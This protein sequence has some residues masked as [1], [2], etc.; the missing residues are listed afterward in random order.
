MFFPVV[1]SVETTFDLDV[2]NKNLTEGSDD[3]LDVKQD[4]E[5]ALFVEMRKRIPGLTGLIVTNIR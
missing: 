3:Y 5:M 1:V 4:A 2:S